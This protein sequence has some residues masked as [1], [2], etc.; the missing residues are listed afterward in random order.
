MKQSIRDWIRENLQPWRVSPERS[1]YGGLLGSPHAFPLDET[2]L[3]FFKQ[4][5]YQVEG[6]IYED[7]REE[8]ML[9]ILQTVSSWLPERDRR[10]LDETVAFGTA[11]THEP[12][13]CAMPCLEGYAILFDLRL[14]SLLSETTE[15]Q[16]A[17][18]IPPPIITTDQFSLALNTAILSIF[19]NISEE[20]RLIPFAN[21]PHREMVDSSLWL[22]SIFLLGHEFGHVVRHHFEEAPRRHSGLPS[23]AGPDSIPVLDL[24]HS[25]EFEADRY[26]IELMLQGEIIGGLMKPGTDPKSFWGGNCF[27]LGWLFSILGAVETLAGRLDIAITDS[28]PPAADR[29]ERIE[30]S[31]QRRVS[32]DPGM[33][34]LERWMRRLALDAAEFGDLPVVRKERLKEVGNCRPVPYEIGVA[35]WEWQKGR[36]KPPK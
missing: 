6:R 30:E 2:Q 18:A 13:A 23:P 34:E 14:D 19:F 3:K 10:L 20:P 4:R 26:A 36:E 1:T 21:F 32:I 7:I 28:H 24:R 12:N 5:G 16:L 29:W 25:Q 17:R 22:M 31:I 27:S 8:E 35:F 15:L 33:I 9:G 11:S